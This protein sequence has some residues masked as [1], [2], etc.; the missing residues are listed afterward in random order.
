MSSNLDYSDFPFDG[1]CSEQEKWF[2][3]KRTSV[4]RYNVLNS[5]QEEAFHLKERECTLKYYH[6]QKLKKSQ[7]NEGG[8]D[9][10]GDDLEGVQYLEV[11]DEKDKKAQDKE[12][13]QKN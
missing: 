8:D 10:K 1:T 2:K 6:E 9:D 5:E 3:A 11:D 13:H 4:W 7:Q 12:V